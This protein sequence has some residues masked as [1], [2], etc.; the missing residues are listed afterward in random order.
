MQTEPPVS[1]QFRDAMRLLAAAPVMVTTWV[2]GRPWGLTVSA[3]CSISVA[4][5]VLLVSLQRHTASAA[6]IRQ[7]TT[8]GVSI[9]GGRLQAVAQYG[10]APGQPKFIEAFCSP[11]DSAA[12]D[13][14]EG[15]APPIVAGCLA[16][17]ECAVDQLIEAGDHD[18]FLGA[19]TRAIREPGNVDSPLVYH[20]GGYHTLPN[21]NIDVVDS[22][23]YPCPIPLHFS[24]QR[25]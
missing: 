21:E 25:A 8:F 16:H 6:A 22:L 24:A 10:A 9:L 4:P 1:D 2:D 11:S 17:V 13:A 18:L 3:C 14:R 7:A 5:P 15:P 20:A 23:G 12:D 19:V